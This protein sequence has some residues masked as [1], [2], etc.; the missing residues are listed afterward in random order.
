MTSVVVDTSALFAMLLEEPDAARCRHR[1]ADC[2]DAIMSS[3]TLTECLVVGARRGLFADV[4]ALITEYGF[5]IA[6][7][8]EQIARAAGSA[9]ALWGKGIH[10]AKLNFGDCFA[11]ALAKERGLPLLFVG[12]DFA[13]TDV[14]SALAGP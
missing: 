4:E 2:E 13:L 10:P 12:E 7:V 1:L 6:S 3:A 14:R 9:Y 11:Y 8:S 5:E